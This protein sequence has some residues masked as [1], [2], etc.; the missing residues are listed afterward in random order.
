MVLFVLVLGSSPRVLGSSLF[1][2]YGLI[3][4]GLGVLLF[5]VLG[6]SPRVLG[7]GLP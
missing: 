4:F 7:F 3:G 2:S 6:S 5:L 1:W